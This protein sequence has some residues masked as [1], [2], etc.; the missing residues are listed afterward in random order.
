MIK[1]LLR[2]LRNHWRLWRWLRRW[3]K[4][5]RPQRKLGWRDQTGGG[6]RTNRSHLK[7]AARR[8]ARASKQRNRKCKHGGGW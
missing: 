6:H 7:N 1:R 3:G 2:W 5:Y 4:P 8:R